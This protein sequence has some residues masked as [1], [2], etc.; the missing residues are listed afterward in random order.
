V[1]IATTFLKSISVHATKPE[2]KQVIK[3]IFINKNENLEKFIEKKKRSVK[4]TPAVTRVE[5]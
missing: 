4:Y 1:D 3:E 5:E 2:V